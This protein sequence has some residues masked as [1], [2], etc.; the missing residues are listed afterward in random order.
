M[1]ELFS[2]MTSLRR[3]FRWQSSCEE[4]DYEN[5]STLV[6]LTFPRLK[7]RG[8]IVLV[9]STLVILEFQMHRI[10]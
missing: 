7:D 5:F 4:D 8:K 3:M 1:C 10:S 2:S 6:S 9:E